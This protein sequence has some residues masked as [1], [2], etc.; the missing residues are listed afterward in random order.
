[1]IPPATESPSHSTTAD[2]SSDARRP[3]K[4]TEDEKKHVPHITEHVH[5]LIENNFVTRRKKEV[6]DRNWI[7]S[8]TVTASSPEETEEKKKG[9][10][11][12]DSCPPLEPEDPEYHFRQHLVPDISIDRYLV[13][14][15]KYLYI[16]PEE[17]VA[18]MTIVLVYL[19]RFFLGCWRPKIE[20]A[21]LHMLFFVTGLL[22]YK[23][24]YDT[25]QFMGQYL[26]RISGFEIP[27]IRRAEKQFLQTVNFELFIKEK[28][29]DLYREHIPF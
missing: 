5:A 23:F 10:L 6:K 12:T 1:M 26:A 24:F 21:S 11:E 13:R 2:G 22:A 15:M 20:F 28:T 4:K 19:D 16:P 9:G 27:L 14:I 17:E 8:E 7:A 29:F 25:P 3:E 18:F